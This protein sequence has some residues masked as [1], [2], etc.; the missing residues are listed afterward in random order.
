MAGMKLVIDAGN[1][2]VKIGIF[3]DDDLIEMR[4]SKDF[5]IEE[6]VELYKSLKIEKGILCNSRYIEP[7]SIHSL[8]SKVNLIHLT[9]STSLP[10]KNKY[11]SPSTL[12]KD[13]LA[14]AVGAYFAFPFANNLVID[15]GTAMT[16]NFINNKGEFLGGTIAPGLTMRLK[17]LNHFTGKLPLVEVLDSNQL[18]GMD[19]HSSLSNG[20]INGVVAEIE[21]YSSK[22]QKEYTPLKIILTGGNSSFMSHFLSGQFVIMNDLTLLGLYKILKHNA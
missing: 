4:I 5:I 9:E 22:Y 15:L 6:I 1:S 3:E 17:A 18:Y 20:A 21:Y 7:E 16:T 12:G 11:Q 8:Q 19:T 13:R 2:K 10:I 14:A